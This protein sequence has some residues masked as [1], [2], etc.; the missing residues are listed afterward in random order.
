M[1]NLNRRDAIVGGVLAGAAITLG[2]PKANAS[3]SAEN[4]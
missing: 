4:Q 2:V 3:S 1:K